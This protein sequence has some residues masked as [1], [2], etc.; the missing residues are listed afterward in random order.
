LGREIVV[1]GV[2]IN[3]YIM[4]YY[5]ILGATKNQDL[6]TPELGLGPL[7]LRLDSLALPWPPQGFFRAFRKLFLRGK[8]AP[9]IPAKRAPFPP[10]LPG[11]AESGRAF[12]KLGARGPSLKSPRPFAKKEEGFQGFYL[13]RGKAF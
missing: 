6:P 3:L 13:I 9:Q 1:W 11:P 4:D 7:G 10:V 12:G 8:R 2:Y 5:L